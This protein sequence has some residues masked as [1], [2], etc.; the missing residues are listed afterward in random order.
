ML[1]GSLYMA[2]NY[3]DG[4]EQNNRS[5]YLSQNPLFH[6]LIYQ[7]YFKHLCTSMS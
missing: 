7:E 6:I 3:M 5:V 1:T 2:S 4:S